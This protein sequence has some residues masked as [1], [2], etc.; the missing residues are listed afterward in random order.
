M[1]TKTEIKNDSFLIRQ[2]VSHQILYSPQ[3]PTYCAIILL[4]FSL[5][6]SLIIDIAWIIG[7]SQLSGLRSKS[8]DSN[9]RLHE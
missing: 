1:I 3:R 9:M 6:L 2:S 4:T 7:F 5:D 8:E